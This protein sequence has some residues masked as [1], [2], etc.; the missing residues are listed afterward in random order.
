MND[1]VDFEGVFHLLPSHGAV[2]SG[3]R[4][5]HLLHENYQ[6]S[7]IHTYPDREFVIPDEP[8]PVLVRLI[9]PEVYPCCIWDGRVLSVF[10]GSLLVGVLT[11][12][13]VLNESLRVSPDLYKP[14]WKEPEDLRA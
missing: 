11:I 1:R 5:Q 12:V 3:Y 13:R 4:P 10:E 7:G 9:S 6:S 14:L 8:V 2:K